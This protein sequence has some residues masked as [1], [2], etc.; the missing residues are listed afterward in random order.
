MMIMIR[1]PMR[2]VPQEWAPL[3]KS[4]KNCK[5]LHDATY[6]TKVSMLY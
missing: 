5:S 3:G 4:S 6:S 1:A 2:Q